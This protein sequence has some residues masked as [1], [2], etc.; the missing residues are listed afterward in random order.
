MHAS[1]KNYKTNLLR[2]VEQTITT[3]GML[4]PND[5]V[6]VGVSGGPDSVALLHIL[7]TLAPRFSLRIGVAHLNHCLRQ[8]ASDKDAE[9][10]LSV[11]KKLDLPCFIEKVDVL[12]Y[13]IDN[14]LSLE[15]AARRVRYTF[16][17]QVS[18]TNRFNKIALGH[19]GDD[20]AE[21]VL[22]NLFRGSGPLG[23]AGI[24]PVRNGII[25]RPLIQAKR[26][27]I[28]GFLNKNKI[29]Y[30]ADTSNTDTRYLR[31]RIR[32]QLIPLLKAAY[33]PKII[34]TLNRLAEIIRAEEERIATEIDLLFKK[35][36]LNIQQDHV[37]FAVSRLNDIHI[38]T[39][40]RLFRRAIETIKGDLRRIRFSH[41]D[42]V[43]RLLKNRQ[44][45]A[46]LD[47]PGRI[48]VQQNN[49]VLRFS[50]EKIALR[51]LDPKPGPEEIP[52]FEYAIATP[53]STFIKEI[54]LHIHFSEM[55]IDNLPDV[56]DAG[57]HTG[58]FDQDVIHFPLVLRN[59]RPGDRFKPLG[60]AG[61]QPL[62]KFFIDKKIPKAERGKCSL[63]L[64][65]GKIIWVVGHRIDE[66][67]KV[68]PLTRNV[69]KVDLSLAY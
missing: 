33:N 30:I 38:S 66:S 50:R 20:N 69:L 1:L 45:E 58:F 56:R 43:A 57:R 25:I 24:P 47:F 5:A 55:S 65:R 21:Q 13:Q 46:R 61:T 52:A 42:S 27:E 31:N 18:K 41:I 54:G 68:T 3:Y 19:H 48:R 34:E 59:Y 44:T 2:S 14:R 7:Y 36:A 9:F 6:V 23:L 32:L 37:T 16:Y 4:K 17:N 26:S 8:T 22:M 62:K 40:R 15:E 51:H 67:V 11:A 12:K 28:L 60:M 35:T 29:P 10:V 39:Q 53:E 64:S 49:D 63:L